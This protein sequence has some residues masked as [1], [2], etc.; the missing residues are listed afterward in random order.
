LPPSSAPPPSAWSNHKTERKKARYHKPCRNR[1]CHCPRS[2]L[3]AESFSRRPALQPERRVRS[4]DRFPG[5]FFRRAVLPGGTFRS[6]SFQ[7]FCSV[8]LFLYS[9]SC[10]LSRCQEHLS[11]P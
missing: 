5:V 11:C 3:S 6:P 1:R 8:E 10:M 7:I 4:E 9:L 2:D